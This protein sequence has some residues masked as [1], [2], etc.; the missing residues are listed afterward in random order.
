MLR[1][2][3]GNLSRLLDGLSRLLDFLVLHNGISLIDLLRLLLFIL[4]SKLL[5][6]QTLPSLLLLDLMSIKGSSL[7]LISFLL[8][9]SPL[10]NFIVDSLVELV[11]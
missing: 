1:G 10:L 2:R 4:K 9:E 11:G 6:S 8:I 7:R 3:L 5:K